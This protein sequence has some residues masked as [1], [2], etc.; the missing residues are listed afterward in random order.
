MERI[1]ITAYKPLPSKQQALEQVVQKH[2]D[3]LNREGLVSGRKPIVA[4]AQDGTIVEVF[5]WK[6]KDAISAA[7]SNMEVLRLWEEFGQACEFTPV[8]TV[9]ESQQMFSE[10]TP[11]N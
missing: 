1:V 5:G 3:I 11:A 9:A 4:K 6:S 10:F 8:G 7:H 2:W